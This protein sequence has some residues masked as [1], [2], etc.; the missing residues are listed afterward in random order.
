MFYPIFQ[1]PDSLPMD[2]SPMDSSPWDSLPAG[3]YAYDHH[4]YYILRLTEIRARRHFATLKTITFW[5][6]K[7][8]LILFFILR[9]T[10]TLFEVNDVKTLIHWA[11]ALSFTRAL[12]HDEIIFLFC[13]LLWFLG[14]IPRLSLIRRSLSVGVVEK[15]PPPTTHGGAVRKDGA[16]IPWGWS[17]PECFTSSG[18]F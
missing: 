8:W 11:F 17:L 10:V 16:E 14:I 3:Y 9:F 1:D 5:Q 15:P 18:D 13:L 6:N 2:S 12:F 4:A 7:R